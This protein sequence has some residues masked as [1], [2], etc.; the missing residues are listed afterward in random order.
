MQTAVGLNSEEGGRSGQYET[1]GYEGEIK[2]YR[3]S[4]DARALRGN[5][6]TRPGS[7]R[8]DGETRTKHGGDTWGVHTKADAEREPED[9]LRVNDGLDFEGKGGAELV[10]LAADEGAHHERVYPADL[11]GGREL[12]VLDGGGDE[13]A[14]SA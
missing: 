4:V 9:K 10:P 8:P 13:D 3:M 14:H 6:E 7:Q 11:S 2:G 1:R 5:K 12:E